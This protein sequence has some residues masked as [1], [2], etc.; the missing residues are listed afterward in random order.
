MNRWIRAAVIV[1]LPVGCAANRGIVLDRD[2]LQL[3][4][5]FSNLRLGEGGGLFGAEVRV[6]CSQAPFYQATVRFGSGD[7]CD[8]RDLG[9]EACFRV[10]NVIVVEAI[11]EG[12]SVV[13]GSERLRFVLPRDSGY[14]GTFEGE[15]T[16]HELR[17]TLVF[18]SGRTLVLHLRRRLHP[19]VRQWVTPSNKEM[20]Q[21]RQPLD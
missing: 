15:V 21:A 1:T 4:G 18:E 9:T 14:S 6:V 13:P 16:A 2:L 19:D 7:F 8:P 11:F 5:T 17:G 12:G 3:T 20:Q 10:S